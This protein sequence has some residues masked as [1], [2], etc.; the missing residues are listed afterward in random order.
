MNFL[1]LDDNHHAS[2]CRLSD[3]LEAR[4]CHIFRMEGQ[5]INWPFWFNR[6]AKE[7]LFS[8]TGQPRHRGEW[9]KECNLMI[10]GR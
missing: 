4:K 7:P 9:Y 3:K 8:F 6:E 2:R 1:K 5:R 10:G